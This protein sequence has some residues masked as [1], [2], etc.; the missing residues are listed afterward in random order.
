MIINLGRGSWVEARNHM[1]QNLYCRLPVN[2][3]GKTT[4]KSIFTRLKML[5]MKFLYPPHIYS[6]EPLG[7]VKLYFLSQFGHEIGR[8][9]KTSLTDTYFRI[10]FFKKGTFLIVLSTTLLTTL[11]FFLR[12]KV[13]PKQKYR[14][15]TNNR[16]F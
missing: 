14:E 12:P 4:R 16:I 7:L 11:S 1:S 13:L 3:D 10:L 6:V 5:E 2:N 15:E 9:S 8:I